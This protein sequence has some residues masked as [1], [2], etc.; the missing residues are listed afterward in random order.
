MC[1]HWSS[2]KS[3]SFQV[4]L[5][6]ITYFRNKSLVGKL[7]LDFALFKLTDRSLL[8][9][10]GEDKWRKIDCNNGS[11]RFVQGTFS[12]KAQFGLWA[13]S[14]AFVSG[15]R[16]WWGLVHEFSEVCQPPRAFTQVG[17]LMQ[18]WVEAK[19]P[20]LLLPI[21]PALKWRWEEGWRQKS[22]GIV[23]KLRLKLSIYL[24]EDTNQ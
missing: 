10:K 24:N 9:I 14:V 19:S 17:R 20:G 5:I 6:Y 11:S 3:L 16:L 2:K 13:T 23:T 22:S 4:F 12:V 1:Y 18:D 8:C 15:T 21:L 7:Q